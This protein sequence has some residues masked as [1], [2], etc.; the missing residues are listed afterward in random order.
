M[1]LLEFTAPRAVRWPDGCQ[2][3][4]PATS[5]A[6]QG[7]T[8]AARGVHDL[9]SRTRPDALG[10]LRQAEIIHAL[11]QSPAKRQRVMR[12]DRGG[13]VLQH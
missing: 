8:R 3:A 2:H 13:D 5:H 12:L 11:R 4:T 10:Y 6:D 7:V 1:R 9:S